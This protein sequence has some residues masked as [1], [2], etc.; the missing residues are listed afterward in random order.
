[1]QKLSEERASQHEAAL[2][3]LRQQLESKASSDSTAK[4]TEQRTELELTLEKVVAEERQKA[5]CEL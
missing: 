3:E 1:M 5:S 2:A 4:L